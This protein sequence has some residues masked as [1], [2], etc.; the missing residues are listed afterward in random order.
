MFDLPELPY[1]LK[2]ILILAS[3]V[4]LLRISGKRSI[5]Q[6]TVPES[7]LMIAVGTILIQPLGMKSEWKAIYGGALLIFGMLALSYMQIYLPFIRKWVYGVPSVLI[8][9]GKMDVKEMKKCKMTDDQLEMRLRLADVYNISDVK[10]AIL[11]PSGMLSIDLIEEKKNA[12]KVDVQAIADQIKRLE[13]RL[14]EVLG[15]V[16]SPTSTPYVIKP[17]QDA[18]FQEA[19]I[20]DKNDRNKGYH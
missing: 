5:A 18:L 15:Q 6:L 1:P 4:I 7:V 13:N 16:P 2:A 20:E 10:L 17:R 12:E 3:G 9:D 11:E 8:R 19:V 14:N